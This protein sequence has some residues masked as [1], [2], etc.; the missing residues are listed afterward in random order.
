VGHDLGAIGFSS[1]FC[2][3]LGSTNNT[4][5]KFLISNSKQ[6]RAAVP[7]GTNSKSPTYSNTCTLA[8]IFGVPKISIFTNHIKHCK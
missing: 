7:G 2:N 1:L 8:A 3:S 4:R 6:N 5:H